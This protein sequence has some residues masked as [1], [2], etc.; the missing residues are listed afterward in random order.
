[1]SNKLLTRYAWGVLIYIVAVILWG[2]YVRATGSGAG[3]GAHWPSCNGTILPR[4]E[5]IETLIEFTHRLSSGLSGLFI[6]GLVAWVFRAY[7]KGHI[8]RSGAAL[9]LVFVLTEGALGAGLVLFKLVAHNDSIAR[10]VSIALH[11]VNTFF[12]L[13]SVTLTAWWVQ[14]GKPLRLKNQGTVGTLLAVGFVGMIILGAS[15]AITALGDT[16]FPSSSVAAGLTQDFSATAH[17]LLRLRVWHPSLAVAVGLYLIFASRLIRSLRPLP[18]IEKLSYAL[19]GVF[20]LQ[21]LVGIL[22]IFL[23]APVWMQM[24]HLLMADL[25]W[26]LLVLLT[27]VT[28]QDVTSEA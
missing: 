1:M 9:S 2:A 10:A 17:F 21:L 19:I 28:L 12:L 16:L 22:N 3:C 4:A 24:I 13:A 26:I 8:A 6:L 23:L 7:P 15:G 27:A 20:L 11:L 25:T 5:R 14:G 18:D